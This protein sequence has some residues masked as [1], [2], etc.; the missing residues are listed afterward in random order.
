MTSLSEVYE[1]KEREVTSPERL[2][3]GTALVLSS[4]VLGIVAVLVVTTDLFSF[5][6]SDVYAARKIAGILGGLAVPAVLVGVFTVLPAGRRAQ[7]AAAISASIC[8]LGVALFSYAYPHHWDG[9][10]QDLTFF[11]SVVYLVGLF[12]AVWCLFTVVVNFKMRNDPG[13]A[14][15][16]NVT[17]RGET[18]IVEVERDR[19]MGGVGLMGATPD[20]DVETQTN[21]PDESP[22]SRVSDAASSVAS[23][24]RDVA[25][26]PS[27]GLGGGPRPTS[28]GGTDA[29]E[30]S[31]PMDSPRDRTT[32]AEPA[33]QYCGNCHHFEYQRGSS[34][35]VPYCRYDGER[36]DDMD[37]CE[38]WEANR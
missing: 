29:R 14:L 37:P 13:G 26:G 18:K 10:G 11:V 12:S 23:A 17:R 7:A 33:D 21:R 30:I 32:P 16:M 5:V 8:L 27:S 31:S 4:A 35:M 19:G 24:A 25:T 36:M 1:R 20:G 34:G 28:D 22:S 38:A 15:E 6:A 2:Y 9:H 3:A